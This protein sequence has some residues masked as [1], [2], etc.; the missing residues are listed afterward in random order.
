M[1]KTTK[2]I[3]LAF[4]LTAVVGCTTATYGRQFKPVEE[5][6]DQYTLVISTGGLA[7][8]GVA[9]ERLEEKEIPAFLEQHPEYKSYKILSK[10][11]RLVPSG[12]TFVVE[13]YRDQRS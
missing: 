13:F 1:L 4:I 3:V 5:N 2:Y 6:K 9:T 11:F 12:V 10:R 8:Y 7:G